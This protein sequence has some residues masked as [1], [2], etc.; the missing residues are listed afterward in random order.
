MGQTEFIYDALIVGSG[1]NSMVAG[2]LLAKAGWRVCVLERS[3]TLGGAVQTAEIT[4]PGFQHDV[5]SGWHILFY[6]SPSHKALAEELANTDL[7]Y[8]ESSL[9][10]ASVDPS[11]RSSFLTRSLEENVVELDRFGDGAAWR[12]T[13]EEFSEQADLTL[14]LLGTELWSRAG[15]SLGLH[16][17]ERLHLHGSVEFAGHALTSARDWLTETF[18]SDEARAL[19]APWVLHTGLAPE[20]ATSGMMLKIMGVMLQQIGVPVPRGGGAKLIEALGQVIE[21]HGGECLTGQ[22]ADNIMIDRG[23]AHGVATASG[24]TFQARY[25]VICNVTP[26]QLYGRLLREHHVEET[27]SSAAKRFRYGRGNMQMH[28]AL[29]RPLR[30]RADE[31]LNRTPVINLTSGLDG[32][33]RAVNEATRGFLPAEPTVCVGQPLLLDPSRAPDGA[34]ILWIQLLEAPT[35][36]KGDAAGQIDVR[37]GQWTEDVR[38]AYADRVQQMIAHQTVD[39]ESSILKRVTLSPAD[40]ENHNINLVHGDPYSGSCELSQNLLFRPIAG[41]ATHETPFKELFHIGASTW[42]GPGLSGSSGHLVATRLVKK[43]RLN[44]RMQELAS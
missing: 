43:H 36:L 29:S 35:F 40:L 4:L 13:C 2:A 28:Y 6:G 15:F 38:E 11:F 39:F 16:A 18:R 17:L 32:V 24:H 8:I 42:P 7:H 19:L 34:G 10:A 25:A 33:S 14:S 21:K 1:I 44:F 12:R 27:I 3:S 37:G 41:Q 30:W 26:T 22:D 5:F 9:T 23:Q 20:S 31:R